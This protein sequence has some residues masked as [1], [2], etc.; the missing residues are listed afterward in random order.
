MAG[1]LG[2]FSSGG[3]RSARAVGASTWL[4]LPLRR[5]PALPLCPLLG[6][7]LPVTLAFGSSSVGAT[8]RYTARLALGPLCVP[9]LAGLFPPRASL[10]PG[11]RLGLEG[12]R[13]DLGGSAPS[14]LGSSGA[15]S[16]EAAFS[17]P[18]SQHVVPLASS[19]DPSFL[20]FCEKQCSTVGS[21]PGSSTSHA[22][23]QLLTLTPPSQSTLGL[24]S[25]PGG[26]VAG[27]NRGTMTHPSL[28]QRQLAHCPHAACGC[29]MCPTL[30]PGQLRSRERN[31]HPSSPQLHKHPQ[32]TDSPL[33]TRSE[34]QV[35]SGI[36]F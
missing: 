23:R 25:R 32:M 21:Y 36:F 19:L 26:Y 30:L 5:L 20:L 16:A 2:T 17:F 24:C 11:A 8:L 28:G 35:W 14:A 13:R 18:F 31:P 22:L 27:G 10:L 29:R 3:A 4:A 7:T 33:L 34:D 12:S 1:S 15:S 9:G 6:S